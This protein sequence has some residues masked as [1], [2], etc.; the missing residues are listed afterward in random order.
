[1]TAFW[2]LFHKVLLRKPFPRQNRRH[3]RSALHANKVSILLYFTAGA[4][5]LILLTEMIPRRH[6]RSPGTACFPQNKHAKLQA[7]K[8]FLSFFKKKEKTVVAVAVNSEIA[9]MIYKS[10]W[11]LVMLGKQLWGRRRG[12]TAGGRNWFHPILGHDHTRKRRC[13][14]HLCLSKTRRLLHP[15]IFYSTNIW[16]YVLKLLFPFHLPMIST[17]EGENVLNY[18]YNYQRVNNTFSLW[19]WAKE[20][21]N[22]FRPG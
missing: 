12:V 3:S 8:Y 2:I 21:F 19:G 17:Q 7:G 4:F 18:N 6:S 1:M 22:R 16:N 13:E 20:D 9:F 5:P 11:P 10:V 15:G 14:R